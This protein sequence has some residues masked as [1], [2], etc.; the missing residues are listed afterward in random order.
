METNM[1]APVRAL[2][3]SGH[4]KKFH[5]AFGDLHV[6]QVLRSNSNAVAAMIAVFPRLIVGSTLNSQYSAK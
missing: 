4:V 2:T 5:W 1:Y 6:L 3:G